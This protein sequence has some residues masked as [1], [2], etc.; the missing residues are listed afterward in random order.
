MNYKVY[1]VL[2]APVMWVPTNAP[3]GQYIQFYFRYQSQLISKLQKKNFIPQNTMAAVCY[4]Q[5]TAIL[6][7][8]FK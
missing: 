6:I 1:S 2:P 7:K 5:A 3:Q 8:A 4:T